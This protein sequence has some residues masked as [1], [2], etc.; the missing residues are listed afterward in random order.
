MFRRTLHKSDLFWLGLIAGAIALHWLLPDFRADVP[1][2]SFQTGP[3][4]KKAYYLLTDRLEYGVRRNFVPLTTLVR[5]QEGS[6]ADNTFLLLGPA[7][8]PTDREW[9]SLASFVAAGGSL[10]FAA[11]ADDPVFDAKPFGVSSNE[12]ERP[13]DLDG[14]KKTLQVDLGDLEGTFSWQSRGE[15]LAADARQIVIAEGRVQA[16]VQPHGAGTAVFVASD[17]PFANQSLTWLDNA[18][19][20]FRLLESAG[21]RSEIVFD[22][23][24]NTSGTPKVVAVLLDRPLRSFTVHLFALLAAFG[25]WR[26]RPFGPL[27]PPSV[28]NGRE[29]QHPKAASRAT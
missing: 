23:S 12:L 25:W 14:R 17:R 10:V 15:L 5:R 8:L 29:R 1:S 2:D 3:R 19:L 24:L 6:E 4:G 21:W 18:V 20:A 11:P 27:A 9:E 28:P 22:E 7:R 13:I 26:S 16:V